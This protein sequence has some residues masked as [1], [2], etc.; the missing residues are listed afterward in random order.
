MFERIKNERMYAQIVEQIC[1][2]IKE[3]TLK[4]GDKLPSERLLIEKLGVSRPSVREA[5]AVLDILGIVETKGG[6]GNFIADNANLSSYKKRL[7]GLS[8]EESS[9]ELLQAR[10]LIEPEIAGLAAENAT[11]KDIK[12]IHQ[13]LAKITKNAKEITEFS[14]EFELNLGFHLNVARATHNKILEETVGYLI[15]GL[16]GKLWMKLKENIWKEGDRPQAY[17]KEHTHIFEAIEKKNKES[18]R[19]RMCQHLEGA[20]KEMFG[21]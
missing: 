19:E 18:A 3:D 20:E 1:R 2:L 14:T 13:S 8:I 7:K 12:A 11:A 5:L 4:P 10:E 21:D 16:R 15:N 9:F 6:K 17:F